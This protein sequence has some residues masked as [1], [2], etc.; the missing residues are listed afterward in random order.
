[1]KGKVILRQAAHITIRI[2]GVLGL[3]YLGAIIGQFLIVWQVWLL[4][5]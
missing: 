1:M 5:W 2:L 3:L 4:K